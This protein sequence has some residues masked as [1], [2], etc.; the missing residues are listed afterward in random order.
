MKLLKKLCSILKFWSKEKQVFI[1]FTIDKFSKIPVRDE[2][3]L[4]VQEVGGRFEIHK[5]VIKFFVPAE[6]RDFVIMKYPFLEEVAY[7]V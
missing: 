6:Y 7:V 1:L 3:S 5:R 4:Y 2:V